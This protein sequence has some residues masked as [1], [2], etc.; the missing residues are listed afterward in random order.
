M[1]LDE[2]REHQSWDAWGASTKTTLAR[3]HAQVWGFSNA[4]DSLSV[5]LR[6]LRALAHQALGWPDGDADAAALGLAGDDSSGADELD[7]EDES[8][9]C[10]SGPHRPARTVTI[11]TLD[12]RGM[13]T[14][15][16]RSIFRR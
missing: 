12:L 11:A 9:G 5:V 6:Y 16:E 8:L 13:T 1:L 10:S 14:R 3:P 15:V 7:D 2:L 4:G